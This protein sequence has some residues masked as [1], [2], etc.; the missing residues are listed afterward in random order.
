MEGCSVFGS[1]CSTPQSLACVCKTIHKVG[2]EEVELHKYGV[3]RED[4]SPLAGTSG[5]EIEVDGNEAE[6]TEEDVAVDL[7]EFEE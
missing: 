3:D 6:R 7:E 5:S 4:D 1:V 2:E